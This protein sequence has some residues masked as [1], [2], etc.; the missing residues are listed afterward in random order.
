MFFIKKCSFRDCQLKQSSHYPVSYYPIWP[1]FK[2]SLK[3]SSISGVFVPHREV[4]GIGVL[5]HRVRLHRGALPHHDQEHCCQMAI[6]RLLDRTCLTL[7]T[8]GLWLCYVALQNV[9]PSFP[10][11]APPRPPPWRNPRKGR[12]H[13]LQRNIAEP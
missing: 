13:I 11:I 3:Y 5:R 8:S 1:V 4:H 9:I 10:R 7:R 12:D 2:K 6:A